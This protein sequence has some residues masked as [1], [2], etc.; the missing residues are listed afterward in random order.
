MVRDA[1]EPADQLSVEAEMAQGWL[2]IRVD[3]EIDI[4]SVPLLSAEFD[5]AALTC[6]PPQVAVDLSRVSFCDSSGLGLLAKTS[7]RL[8]AI[9]GDLVL[10]RPQAQML[11]RLQ[12]AGLT[13][14]IGIRSVLP[15]STG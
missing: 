1:D 5:L 8:R 7:K 4:G 9:G 10:I 11:R 15:G 6:T 13:E 12:W 3:G 2:V 14:R